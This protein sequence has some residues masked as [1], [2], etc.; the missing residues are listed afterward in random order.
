M[1]GTFGKILI[2]GT[3]EVAKDCCG[4]LFG[5]EYHLYK[6]DAFDYSVMKSGRRKVVVLKYKDIDFHEITVRPGVF[7]RCFKIS[8][9]QF[10]YG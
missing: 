8:K 7:K 4:K 9:Y 5:K 1:I 3:C 6:G 2:K 10:L